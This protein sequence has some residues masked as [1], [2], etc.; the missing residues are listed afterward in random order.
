[1]TRAVV[2]YVTPWLVDSP[3]DVEIAEVEAVSGTLIIEVSVA[4]DDVG[5]IIGKRGR[6]IHSLRL[7]ARAAA[8]REGSNIMVEVVD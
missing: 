4:P 5:K 6:I 3:D 8:Q 2:E 1:M 7:L